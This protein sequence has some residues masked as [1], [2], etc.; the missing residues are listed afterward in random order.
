MIAVGLGILLCLSWVP[1]SAQDLPDK[2]IRKVDE[3][4]SFY[5]SLSNINI[6]PL[7]LHGDSVQFVKIYGGKLEKHQLK[8]KLYSVGELSKFFTAIAI[9]KLAEQG[10]LSLDDNIS[11]Y[12]PDLPSYKDSIKIINLLTH[13]SGL[14]KYNK[15][16][17]NNGELIRDYLSSI[18]LI[19][20]PGNTTIY[21]PAD[22]YILS[23]IIEKVSGKSY[24]DY[25]I[26][27]FFKKIGIKNVYV[28]ND[29][30]EKNK[31]DILAYFIN[32]NGDIEMFKPK[33]ENIKGASGVFM[34]TDDL[35]SFYLQLHKGEIIN[36]HSVNKYLDGYIN[37]KKVENSSVYG[38]GGI[39][40]SVYGTNYV[41]ESSFDSFGMV[42]FLRIPSDNITVIILS[43]DIAFYKLRYLTISTSNVFT[44][45][46][47]YPGDKK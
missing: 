11:K 47:L 2:K 40:Q 19:S 27:N 1:N 6:I 14:P 36:L 12:F 3:I 35:A 10:D 37:D 31:V 34:S 21:N 39:K 5:D 24:S 44:R 33:W 43:N 45:K 26:K 18:H 15:V 38:L 20:S 13:Q 29:L 7:V 28:A 30:I 22:Y 25:M 16:K 9:I 42:S 17:L 41:Y 32:K 4:Y 23:E 46:Y 8:K